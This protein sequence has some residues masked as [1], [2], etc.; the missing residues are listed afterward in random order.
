MSKYIVCPHCEG[1]GRVTNPSLS[2]WTGADI[3]ADPEGFSAM[4]AGDYDVS[5]PRCKGQ[6]VVLND[7]AALAAWD[8]EARERLADLR[9]AAQESGDA[10]LYYN[11]SSYYGF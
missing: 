5:C 1:E 9:L 10:D 2:V 6:R 8:A 11:A 4:L 7:P 3:D